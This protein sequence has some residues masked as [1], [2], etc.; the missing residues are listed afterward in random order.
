MSSFRC[1]AA[2]GLVLSS[3][4]AP[5]EA[6]RFDLVRP[7]QTAGSCGFAAAASVL[8]LVWGVETSEAD[9]TAAHVRRSA[10]AGSVSFQAIARAFEE[11]H[12][13]ARGYHM[14]YEQLVRTVSCY[15]P[16]IVHYGTP[17]RHFVLVYAADDAFVLVGDPSAGVSVL[18][19]ARFR[20]RWSGAVLL[21]ASQTLSA[22]HGVIRKARETF[23]RRILSL[24]ACVR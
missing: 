8:T 20:A 10:D 21:C 16:V 2:L 4:V 14:T 9:L 13:P 24:E 22:D 6:L 15:A 1:A 12:I 5:K 18:S 19:K 17:R 3:V 7:Q 23:G 11:A